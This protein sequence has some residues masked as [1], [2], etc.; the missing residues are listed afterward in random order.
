[1]AKFKKSVVFRLFALTLASVI[2]LACFAGCGK[3]DNTDD[4]TTLP[5][6]TDTTAPVVSFNGNPLTGEADYDETQLNARPVFISVENHPEARPQWGIT[7]SDIVF[8]MVAE[9]GITRTL[10]VFANPERVPEKIGPIRS[11]RYYF[12]DLAAGFD[13]YFVHIGGNSYSENELAKYNVP[14][15]DGM[16]QN[17]YHRDT[18]RDVAYEHTAY[19]TKDDIVKVIADNGYRSEIEEK[20]KAPFKFNAEQTKL[21][22]GECKSYTV[23]FSGDYTY[24]YTYDELTNTYLSALNGSPFMGSNG[25]QQSFTNLFVLY[26]SV[27]ALNNEPKLK[28]IDLSEGHGKYISNGTFEDITWKKGAGDDV[29]KFYNAQG[30]EVKLNIGRS[31]IALV[32]TGRENIQ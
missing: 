20:Y 31:Y 7:E 32:D 18:S 26:T 28:S 21:A 6:Q 14:D 13:A 11:A 17:F 12:A 29:L 4:D 16:S 30:D 1:M 5:E 27:T 2:A 25:V 19:S 3:K 24:T 15:I 10:Q 23:S 22:G 9:G 8:E